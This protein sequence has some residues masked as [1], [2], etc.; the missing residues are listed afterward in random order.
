MNSILLWLLSVLVLVCFGQD[1]DTEVSGNDLKPYQNQ[2]AP[3][4]DS[5]SEVV[6]D[7][8]DMIDSDSDTESDMHFPY[9]RLFIGLGILMTMCY[10]C[11][12]SCGMCRWA[13]CDKPCKHCRCSKRRRHRS[14]I[15]V[16]KPRISP[17][18]ELENVTV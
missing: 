14:N 4:T 11:I 7:N 16:R 18:T 17:Y 3:D 8:Q 2:P 13:F 6:I 9:V 12:V 1:G 10:I 5:D 15:K